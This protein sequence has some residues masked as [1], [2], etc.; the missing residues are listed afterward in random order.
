MTKILNVPDEYELV[1]FLPIGVTSEPI[2]PWERKSLEKEYGL[3]DSLKIVNKGNYKIVSI[4]K[5]W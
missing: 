1:C 4:I 2:L 3:M 5:S